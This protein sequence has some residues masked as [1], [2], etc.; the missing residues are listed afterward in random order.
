MT[1]A[2]QNRIR[3]FKEIL[4]QGWSIGRAM[5]ISKIKPDEYLL[6]KGDPET[7]DLVNLAKN[8]FRQRQRNPDHGVPLSEE[9]RQRLGIK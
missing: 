5:G 4:K 8:Q 9:Q 7:L 2:T 1:P 3:R 6:A